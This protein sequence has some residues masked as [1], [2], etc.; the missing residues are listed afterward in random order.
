[1]QTDLPG[2]AKSLD[3]YLDDLYDLSTR[4]H[5]MVTLHNDVERKM[6]ECPAKNMVRGKLRQHVRRI[7]EELQATLHEMVVRF[8][9]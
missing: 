6:P 9:E 7:D 1:M 3:Q 2:K 4:F 5:A 8:A